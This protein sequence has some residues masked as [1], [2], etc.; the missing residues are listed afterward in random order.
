MTYTLS[1]RH[2]VVLVLSL[3]L[4]FSSLILPAYASPDVS[5]DV[6]YKPINLRDYQATFGIQRRTEDDVLD[7]QPNSQAELIYG[8]AGNDQQ[9]LLAHMKLHASDG[10]DIVLMERF[11]HLT[12]SVDCHGEDGSLSLTFKS[13]AAF[14]RA[15]Q[16]WGFINEAEEIKFLLI[17]NHDDCS[18]SDQRQPY[19]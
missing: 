16:A 19:M 15:I 2:N 7:F 4:A 17:T 9:L 8:R 13:K 11:E 12:E 10:L 3:L 14:N 5:D 18:P 1:S 6:V